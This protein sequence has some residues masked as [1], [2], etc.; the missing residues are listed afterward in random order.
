MIIW[1]R[2]YSPF[3]MGGSCHYDG[4]IEVDPG[5]KYSLGNGFFGYLIENPVTKNTHVAEATSGAFVGPTLEAVRRDIETAQCDLEGMKKQVADSV[6]RAKKVQRMDPQ[7]FWSLMARAEE[8]SEEGDGKKKA[9]GVSRGNARR[10]KRQ[11]GG[12]PGRKTGTKRR[13]VHRC[14]S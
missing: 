13:P 10:G 14:K 5:L 1:S 8:T 12:V 9:H 6:E 7:E 11:D 3:I 2:F 4:G